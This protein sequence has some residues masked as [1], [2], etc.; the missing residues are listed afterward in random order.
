MLFDVSQESEQ[1]V[2]EIDVP[3]TQDKKEKSWVYRHAEK[4]LVAGVPHFFCLVK[5]NKTGK[6]CNR[7]FDAKDG[8]TSSIA[9][10][11]KTK[12]FLEPGPKAQQTLDQF[13][14]PQPKV[15]QFREA[16]AELV[17]KQYLPFSLIQ[18]KVLQD[19]YKAFYKEHIKT[20]VQ[21]VFVTDKTIAADIARM[22]NEYVETLKPSFDSKLSLCMDVWTGPNRMSF[23]GITFTYLDDNFYIQRGLLDMI[24]MSKSHTG[25]NIAKLFQRVMDLY[26]IGK[27]NIGGVE[28]YTGTKYSI[29][30]SEEMDC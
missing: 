4:R 9:K 20:G 7:R 1:S 16:F 3:K 8:V 15:K 18:E 29:I 13:K 21:P 10:H 25:E 5:V 6:I 26:C 22:A 23:L 12:H 2:E 14:I 19:S 30:F 28:L 24:K 27:D 11:L 17:A